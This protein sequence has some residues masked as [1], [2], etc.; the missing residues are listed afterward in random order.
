L[1]GWH[2]CGD[3][4][5]VLVPVDKAGQVAAV[6]LF[7]LCAQPRGNGLVAAMAL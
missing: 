2:L 6:R 3:A 7:V 1:L 5:G 4:A